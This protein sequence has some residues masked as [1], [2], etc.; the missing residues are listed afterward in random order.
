M[1]GQATWDVGVLINEILASRWFKTFNP[2]YMLNF[3]DATTF[4]AGGFTEKAITLADFAIAA[5]GTLKPSDHPALAALAE[6]S[7]AVSITIAF[8]RVGD[9]TPTGLKPG[10][11][12]IMFDSISENFNRRGS[13]TGL[14]GY[15]FNQK[16]AAAGL[17][18]LGR[19]LTG[20]PNAKNGLAAT[21]NGIVVDFHRDLSDAVKVGLPEGRGRFQVHVISMPSAIT[22][23]TVK[24]QT[25]DVVAF[26][27]PTDV[28][29]LDVH[30]LLGSG[31][32]GA[33][34]VDAPSGVTMQRYLRIV[35]NFDGRFGY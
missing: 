30:T 6:K 21:A 26:S 22:A 7:A 1:P 33:V 5:G 23:A 18:M 20:E 25:D 34:K 2:S 12:C 28:V 27:S 8:P 11:V 9:D 32:D 17:R 35:T 14:A 15:D 19:M 13:A 24:L 16:P 29:T 10:N 4:G 31:G 3:E